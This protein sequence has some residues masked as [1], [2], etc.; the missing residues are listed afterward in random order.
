MQPV[1]F[2]DN[3]NEQIELIRTTLEGVGRQDYE[4]QAVAVFLA[5][6]DGGWVA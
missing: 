2:D 4:Y 1:R 3:A 6:Q 5:L